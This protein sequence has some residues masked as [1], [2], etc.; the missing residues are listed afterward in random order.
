LRYDVVNDITNCAS[1]IPKTVLTK[2]I[3]TILARK[4][5]KRADLVSGDDISS[6]LSPASSLTGGATAA[7]KGSSKQSIAWKTPLQETSIKP[8]GT[9]GKPRNR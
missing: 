9:T 7:S 1:D 8:S 3:A 4:V 6:V 2:N 5:K